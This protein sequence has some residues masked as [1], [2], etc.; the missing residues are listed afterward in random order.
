M[1]G[2]K[3]LGAPELGLGGNVADRAEDV[4]GDPPSRDPPPTG[5]QRPDAKR[6]VIE[7]Q[8]ALRR[9]RGG[10]NGL[11]DDRREQLDPVGDQLAVI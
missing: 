1:G 4:E 3:R 11:E 8:R 9:P 2:R 6:Q 10:A 5:V 7:Q